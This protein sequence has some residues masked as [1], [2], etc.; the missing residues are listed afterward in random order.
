MEFE[1]TRWHLEQLQNARVRCNYNNTLS[2]WVT[3]TEQYQ[4]Q[5]E[6]KT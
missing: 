6:N 3:A 1:Q 5:G 2:D 4:K